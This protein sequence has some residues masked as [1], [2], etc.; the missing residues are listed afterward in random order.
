MSGRSCFFA[1]AAKASKSGT[2][3]RGLPIVSTYIA[4]VLSSINASNL[5]ASVPSVSV[6]IN[7]TLI[8]RRGRVCLN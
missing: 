8:P 7:L 4:L 6:S 1:T 2:L 5:S 3:P